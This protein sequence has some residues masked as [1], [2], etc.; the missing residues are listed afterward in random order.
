MW[1]Q[2]RSKV[3]L[4]KTSFLLDFTLKCCIFATRLETNNKTNND[5][6]IF[7]DVGFT[8]DNGDWQLCS[9]PD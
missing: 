6:A 7:P 9:A 3:K 2:G 8:A 1:K 4:R 5:K